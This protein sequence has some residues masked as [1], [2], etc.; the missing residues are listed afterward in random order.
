MFQLILFYSSDLPEKTVLWVTT[1]PVRIRDFWSRAWR[2]TQ[3]RSAKL[4]LTSRPMVLRINIF[5]VSRWYFEVVCYATLLRQWLTNT[6]LNVKGHGWPSLCS[7][8]HSGFSLLHL[9]VLPTPRVWSSTACLQPGHRPVQVP[10]F[11]IGKMHGETHRQ[12]SKAKTWKLNTSFPLT[13]NCQECSQWSQ[14]AAKE[15]GK[16]NL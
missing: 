13:S 9:V 16:C 4:Q 7:T 11:G 6:N 14:L 1:G 10:A 8:D 15:S 3:P 5:V 2:G 12:Y